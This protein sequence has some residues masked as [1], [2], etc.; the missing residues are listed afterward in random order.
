MF[1]SRV[2][3]VIVSNART[4]FA[5]DLEFMV[6]AHAQPMIAVV[7]TLQSLKSLIGC[8]L[9]LVETSRLEKNG[10]SDEGKS[11]FQV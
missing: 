1:V 2:V 5:R 10:R 11:I 8:E 4:L 7:L 3:L 6:S 9:Y